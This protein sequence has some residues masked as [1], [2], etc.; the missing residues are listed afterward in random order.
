M[1]K[2]LLMT[3]SACLFIVFLAAYGSNPSDDRVGYLA[4]NFTVQNGSKI[5]E[6][7]QM[8]GKYVLLTFWTSADA[9]SRIANLQYD[10]AVRG[11]EGIEHV[12]VNF[13]R[14]EGIYR[15]IVK[16]DGLDM[17][18]QFYG[19]NKSRVYSRYEL[20]RGMK[21]FLLDPSGKIVAENPLPDELN[22]FM[23]Q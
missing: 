21:S 15:G 4:P 16:N 18:S 9:E 13:D 6:I 23:E 22:R 20:S 11:M 8:K 5:V 7:Q 14:S 17:A 19:G 3:L 10:R 1:K 12:A 2:T